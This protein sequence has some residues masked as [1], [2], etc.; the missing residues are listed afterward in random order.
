MV[1]E[2][3]GVFRMGRLL[4]ST[5]PPEHVPRG[6]RNPIQVVTREHESLF[7][8]ISQLE[9]E[10]EGF[11]SQ[12]LSCPRMAVFLRGLSQLRRELRIHVREEEEILFP[13]IIDKEHAL[14]H[15]NDQGEA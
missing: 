5:E 11:L 3:R 10:A 13:A 6:L 7:A 14:S 2:A 8:E 1:K 4:D 12:G 9:E 15:H